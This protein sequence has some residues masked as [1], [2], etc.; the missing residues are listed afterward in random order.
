MDCLQLKEVQISTFV[1]FIHII[2]A[3]TVIRQMHGPQDRLESH[4]RRTNKVGGFLT[5]K[6]LVADVP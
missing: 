3:M 4:R 1:K 6:R 2:G 5:G